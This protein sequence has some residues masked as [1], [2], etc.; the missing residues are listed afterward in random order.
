MQQAIEQHPM[1]A[2]ARVVSEGQNISEIN[3][4]GGDKFGSWQARGFILAKNGQV[5]IW[6]YKEY[7][8][9]QAAGQTD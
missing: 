6:F 5:M 2:Y 4:S 1:K 9:K 3:I 8:D 7:N